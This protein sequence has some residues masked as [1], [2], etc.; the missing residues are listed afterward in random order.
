MKPIQD[1]LN[2]LIVRKIEQE[3]NNLRQ[4]ILIIQSYKPLN[5]LNQLINSLLLSISESKALHYI[6]LINIEIYR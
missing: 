5:S 2:S 1:S 6:I 3:I 4:K